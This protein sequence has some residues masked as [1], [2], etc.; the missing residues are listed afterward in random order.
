[1]GKCYPI[2]SCPD[3]QS[4]CSMVT[5]LQTTQNQPTNSCKPADSKQT[6]LFT[7]GLNNWIFVI[8]HNTH[9]L[10]LTCLVNQSCS[11]LIN[12]FHWLNDHIHVQYILLYT[13]R[14]QQVGLFDFELIYLVLCFELFIK[15]VQCTF[16]MS[17]TTSD[18]QSTLEGTQSSTRL[19][20]PIW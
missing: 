7:C 13:H 12:E 6:S 19:Y 2:V 8:I 3:N 5:C 20:P 11:S 10:I 16:K 15:Q 9:I 4:W 18:L 17:T 14:T 1:M